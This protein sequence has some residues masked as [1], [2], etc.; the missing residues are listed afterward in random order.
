M[1]SRITN[2]NQLR[3]FHQVFVLGESKEEKLCAVKIVAKT[4]TPMHG[5]WMI[6]IRP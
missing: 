5:H 2:F 6:E 4:N 1:S 3:G